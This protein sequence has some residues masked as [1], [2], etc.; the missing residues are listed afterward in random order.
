MSLNQDCLNLD[1]KNESTTNKFKWPNKIEDYNL[2]D[3]IGSGTFGRVFRSLCKNNSKECA[4]KCISKQNSPNIN[5][6]LSEVYIHIRLEHENVLQLFTVLEDNKAV[7]LIMELCHGGSLSKVISNEVSRRKCANIALNDKLNPILPY[8]MVS[9]VI[10]Q[11][12]H[13]LEYLHRNS[14][15]HRDINLNNILL[16]QPLNLE[17]KNGRCQIQI[18]LADFGLAI[19]NNM[20]SDDNLL[21]TTICG[22]PG[23]ISPEV[24]NKK[25]N[26]S[27]KSDIFSLGSIIISLIIGHIPKCHIVSLLLKIEKIIIKLKIILETGSISTHGC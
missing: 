12:C 6:I 14:I 27:Y 5:K 21:G 16:L 3:L 23:F 9:S 26:A 10:L 8:P 2:L 18:K 19:D 7:Y 20:I 11:L 25:Q 13:A 1:K 22:T 4:I 17:K 15:V 24:W